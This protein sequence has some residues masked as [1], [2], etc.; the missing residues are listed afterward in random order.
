MSKSKVKVKL[1]RPAIRKIML[2][3][4]MLTCLQG[5]ADKIISTL[6]GYERDYHKGKNRV[7]VG[8]KASTLE[9][10]RGNLKHNTLLKALSFKR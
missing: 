9:A 1:R 3:E 2:S 4:N 10:K 8:I 5:E 7:N 6:D